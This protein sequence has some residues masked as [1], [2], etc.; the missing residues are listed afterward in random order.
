MARIGRVLPSGPDSHLVEVTEEVG[1]ILVDA[2]GAGSL[3][4]LLPV[5]AGEQPDTERL[6]PTG[7]QEIPD[8]V[9]HDH[10]GADVD[11]AAD[12]GTVL[13]AELPG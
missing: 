8:A 11:P 2:V 4:L 12:R 3:Q 5:A 1:G 13:S 7:G 6:G 9:A 10:R